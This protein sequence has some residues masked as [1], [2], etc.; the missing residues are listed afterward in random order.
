[1]SLRKM[2]WTLLLRV[3]VTGLEDIPVSKKSEK[4]HS[5]LIHRIFMFTC[6][7]FIVIISAPHGRLRSNS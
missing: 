2:A 1:M 3:S 6:G 4:W 5:R 7:I